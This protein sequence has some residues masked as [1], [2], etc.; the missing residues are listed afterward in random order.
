MVYK[1]LLITWDKYDHFEEA[2]EV[3]QVFQY[4]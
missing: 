1:S 2:S 3:Q 4:L